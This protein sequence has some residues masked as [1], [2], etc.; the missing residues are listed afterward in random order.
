M[1]II[2]P[3]K[4]NNEV[5]GKLKILEKFEE[6]IHYFTNHMEKLNPASLLGVS[7]SYNALNNLKLKD[8]RTKTLLIKLKLLRKKLNYLFVN[9]GSNF[10]FI[11]KKLILSD[12]LTFEQTKSSLTQKFQIPKSELNFNRGSP[13]QLE[14]DC[15]LAELLSSS[16]KICS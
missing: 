1:I 8:F 7:I 14:S 10:E 11:S 12:I 4:I 16:S 9:D 5:Q 2:N 6:L 15:C 3:N 13:N